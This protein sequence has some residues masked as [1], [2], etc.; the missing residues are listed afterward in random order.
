MW[1][2]ST[3]DRLY[4][5]LILYSL[6][7]TVGPWTVGE[8]IENHIG[9]IFVWGIFIGNEYLPGG[10]TYAYGFFQLLFFYLPL[11]LV[12]AHQVDRRLQSAENPTQ[13]LSKF[14]LIWQHVPIGLLILLQSVM[15]Y[16]LYLEYG[17][18]AVLLCPLRTGSIIIAAL[19]CYHVN[20]MPLSCLRSAASVWSPHGAI[21]NNNAI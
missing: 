21:N 16:F 5:G 1:I 15:A 17:A 8:I 19:L 12:L 4:F 10:F 2:L 6:Y 3:V 7:L 18:I 11:T 13:H 20:A 14:R 9:V